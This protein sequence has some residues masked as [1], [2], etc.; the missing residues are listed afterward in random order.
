MELD[1]EGLITVTKRVRQLVRAN[2]VRR[3]WRR[4]DD[5]PPLDNWKK[6]LPEYEKQLL[7]AYC[8]Y[9]GWDMDGIPTKESLH[10]LDL[11]YIAED[12]EKRGIYENGEG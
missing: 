9:K 1:T 7:D 3:G 5:E 12:F 4:A 10:S 2:N 11:A 8:E 6:R